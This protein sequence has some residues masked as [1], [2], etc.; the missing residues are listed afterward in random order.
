[1]RHYQITKHQPEGLIYVSQSCHLQPYFCIYL[2]I[3]GIFSHIPPDFQI[4]SCYHGIPS[5]RTAGRLPPASQSTSDCY[6]QCTNPHLLPSGISLQTNMFKS[7]PNIRY[8][9]YLWNAKSSNSRQLTRSSIWAWVL[10]VGLTLSNYKSY[11]AIKW[12]KWPFAQLLF[13]F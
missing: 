10:D 4:C 8:G 9:W 5:M 12:H 7:L 13:M 2:C 11:H 6:F 3:V 1:M